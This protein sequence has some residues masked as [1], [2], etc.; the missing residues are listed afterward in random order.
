MVA[1]AAGKSIWGDRLTSLADVIPMMLGAGGA[2]LAAA[3]TKPRTVET[4]Q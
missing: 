2:A 3:S 4:G 1:T